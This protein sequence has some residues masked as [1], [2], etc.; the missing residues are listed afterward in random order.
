VIL[1]HAPNAALVA[2]EQ[3]QLSNINGAEFGG[4]PLTPPHQPDRPSQHWP[5][6]LETAGY[7]MTECDHLGSEDKAL[8]E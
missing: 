4:T 2:Q 5:W 3:L 8:D 7:D 1:L 6:Q